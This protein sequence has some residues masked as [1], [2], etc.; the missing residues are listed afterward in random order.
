MKLYQVQTRPNEWRT[1][2]GR[3]AGHAEYK[4]CHNIQV[5]ETINEPYIDT[6]ETIELAGNYDDTQ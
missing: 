2:R 1:V 6:D 4:A 3:W 5:I